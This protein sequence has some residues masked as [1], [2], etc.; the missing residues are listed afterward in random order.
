MVRCTYE[1]V[2][3]LVPQAELQD[4]LLLERA[5]RNEGRG[6]VQSLEQAQTLVLETFP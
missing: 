3:P 6:V 1:G 2:D 4:D 5:R